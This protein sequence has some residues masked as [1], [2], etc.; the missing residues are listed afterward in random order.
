MICS[1]RKKMGK[2]QEKV[3]IDSLK[4]LCRHKLSKTHPSQ[5][6]NLYRTYYWFRID[7]RVNNQ[8][9]SSQRLSRSC[10]FSAIPCFLPSNDLEPASSRVSRYSP[11]IKRRTPVT[12][13]KVKPSPRKYHARAAAKNGED[14]SVNATW[15]AFSLFNPS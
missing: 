2:A 5:E 4:G 1:R 9:M 8:A 3:R 6:I 12:C 7:T 10:C 13:I 14:N 11:S 15:L